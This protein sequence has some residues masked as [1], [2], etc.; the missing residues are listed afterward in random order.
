MSENRDKLVQYQRLKGY[1]EG[2]SQLSEQTRRIEASRSLSPETK[3]K[4][5]DALEQ[6]KHELA[7]RAP[8]Q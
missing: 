1:A 7:R 5:I 3:R 6:R 2:V 8:V 4:M